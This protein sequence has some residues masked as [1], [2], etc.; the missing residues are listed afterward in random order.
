MPYSGAGVTKQYDETYFDKW[1]RGRTRVHASGEVQRKVALSVASAEYFL[2]RQAR[3]ALDIGCGEGAWQPE[4]RTL[5]PRLRYLG[6][7]PSEYAVTRF[8]HE[9]NIRRATFAE[10]GSLRLPRKFDLVICSDVLHYVR[11]DEIRR[12]V[13]ELVRHTAGIAYLEVLTAEDDIVGDLEG[14]IRRP[15]AWYRR[16]FQGAG[17]RA[18]G[19]YLWLAP[20][21][22]SSAAHLE[23]ESTIESSP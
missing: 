12:G 2:H 7:D 9:R 11:D 4:L 10:L 14:F 18:A 22:Q 8:G 23:I 19:P 1:Y 15:A 13:T 5:R 6:L 3:T 20:S 17:L 21:L 16:L